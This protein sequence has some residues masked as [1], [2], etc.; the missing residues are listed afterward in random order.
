MSINRYLPPY[1][2]NVCIPLDNIDEA[3]GPTECI[4]EGLFMCTHVADVCR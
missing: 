4:L 3:I 2:M 1:A